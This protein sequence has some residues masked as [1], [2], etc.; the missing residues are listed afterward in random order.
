MPGGH[1]ESGKSFVDATIREMKEE[2]GLDIINPTLCGIKQ[3]SIENGRYSF[4]I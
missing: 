3:F 1:V 4:F 2:T